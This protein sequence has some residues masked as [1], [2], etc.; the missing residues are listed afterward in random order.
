MMFT[1]RWSYTHVDD[2]R[3]ARLEES[4][5][6]DALIRKLSEC[7]ILAAELESR[8]RDH[9]QPG[10]FRIAYCVKAGEELFDQFFNAESGY[11]GRYFLSAAE[12]YAANRRILKVLATRL[13]ASA[14][15]VES[16][17]TLQDLHNTWLVEHKR[18]SLLATSARIWLC[19]K[20]KATHIST[21]FGEW[22]VESPKQQDT[23]GKLGRIKNG[24]WDSDDLTMD[25]GGLA[26]TLSR[27]IIVGAFIDTTGNEW[28]N[29]TK[30]FR[31]ETICESGWA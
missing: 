11:R 19:E 25:N 21:K 17:F 13:L 18:R 16:K 31:S 27:L 15:P 10:F 1:G 28:V 6:L 20:G 24:K 5:D 3:R 14:P 12:G 4:S 23:E 8:D 26:P 7:E 9:D 2:A 30:V 22:N 29:H